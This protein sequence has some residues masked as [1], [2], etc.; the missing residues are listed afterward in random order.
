MEEAKVIL[1]DNLNNEIEFMN[2]TE[3]HEKGL[4]HRAISVFI[5]NSNGEWLLQRRAAE[6]YHSASLWTNTC[7][8][9]PLPGETNKEAATRR[10]YEEM[11][12]KCELFEL[13]NFTYKESFENGLTEHELDYVFLGITN[14]KPTINLSEVSEYKYLK[15]SNIDFEINADTNNYTVWFGKIFRKVNDLINEFPKHYF[16]E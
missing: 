16:K 1:V 4:L 15:F 12:L 7:C 8:S 10:L 9:H 5:I 6:K 2:K 14:D 11:G 13:F 3:A